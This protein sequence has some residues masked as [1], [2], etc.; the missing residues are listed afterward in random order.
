[1]SEG[2]GVDKALFAFVNGL[3][4]RIYFK[5]TDISDEFLRDEVLGGLEEEGGH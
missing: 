5:E 1:M 2:S 3:A 4:K